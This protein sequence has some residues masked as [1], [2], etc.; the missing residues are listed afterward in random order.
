MPGESAML[1]TE[2][3]LYVDLDASRASP[4]QEQSSD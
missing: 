2:A 1:P 3:E 4:G